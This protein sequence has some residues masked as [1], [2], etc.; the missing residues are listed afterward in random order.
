MDKNLIKKKIETKAKKILNKINTN[1]DTYLIFGLESCS[2]C[3]NS[4]AY[5]KEQNLQFKYN[6]ALTQQKSIIMIKKLHITIYGHLQ[7]V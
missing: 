5:A 2:Y 7:K 3:K 4:I 1:P 6:K